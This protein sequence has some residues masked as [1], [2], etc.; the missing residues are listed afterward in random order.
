MTRSRH[1]E[2]PTRR[3]TITLDVIDEPGIDTTAVTVL[4]DVLRHLEHEAIIPPLVRL[5]LT[6]TPTA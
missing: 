6:P 4:L 5:E 1:R 2:A 3:I